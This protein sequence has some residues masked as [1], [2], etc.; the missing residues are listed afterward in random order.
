MKN[1]KRPFNW[2]VLAILTFFFISC[3]LDQVENSFEESIKRKEDS[4]T[5][6]L[7][8]YLESISNF[9]L[10]PWNII[11]EET[12]E[13]EEPFYA[14]VHKQFPKS[15]SFNVSTNPVHRGVKS[16]RFEL[17]KGDPSITDIGVRTEV[18]FSQIENPET[19]Y[20]FSIFLP[21][22]G[23]AR[24]SD[25][26]I[27][28]QWLQSG[29]G[30][31]SI[32]LRTL[33]DRFI[34][35]FRS[36]SG[37]ITSHDLSPATKDSWNRFVF[38]IIHS[39]G[40][41]GLVEIWRNGIKI[42][43]KSGPNMYTGN[44]PRWKL[45]IYKPT[46]ENRSTETQIRI[47]FF[48]NIRIGNE[49]A[50]YEEMNPSNTNKSGW[51]PFIPEIKS[52]T[53]INAFTNKVVKEIFDNEIINIKSLDTDKVTIRANFEETFE[54]S[55]LFNLKGSEI[56]NYVDNS[57][58]NTMYGEDSNGDYFNDGGTPIGNYTL[59]TTTYAERSQNGKIGT[60]KTLKFKIINIEES[61]SNIPSVTSFT[62]IK[63]N[64]D[65]KLGSLKDGDIINLEEV[66]TSKLSI[67][68]NFSSTFIGQLRFRLSGKINRE[69]IADMGPYTLYGYNKG[70]YSFGSTGLPAG[71]YSL[72][73]TPIVVENGI[74]KFGQVI[75]IKFKVVE[76]IDK[77]VLATNYLK[78]LT[79]IKANI[80]QDYG[81]IVDGSV[82]Y[83]NQIGTNKLTIRA[84]MVNEF[85][86]TVL[87]EL[88]GT[89]NRKS[90]S[91]A[92]APY[93]LNGYS[94]GDYSFGEGLPVGSYS[95][96]ITPLLILNGKNSIG[97]ISTIN[98]QIK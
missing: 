62:L 58:P 38:H 76:R 49:N 55:V 59:S 36:N 1:L 70:D 61:N 11:F 30:S 79:L 31:P 18:L 75:T 65:Q 28:S 91:T 8:P 74:I 88:T 45:G 57:T 15:H 7:E 25:D 71:D 40:S 54:G 37:V 68:A 84:N 94:N 9:R 82:F 53:L 92:F 34:Y 80:D 86:G 10:G 41:N 26:E 85:T 81:Q 39:S 95:L 16:G 52:Y 27:L 97:E 56:S 44:L 24:D 43:Q 23:Y 2:T 66:G 42:L 77:I 19:W 6:N 69:Y 51:G 3:N 32:S 78:S 96:K 60:R 48:D 73:T 64:V 47:A 50:T 33:N 21:S 22:N 98:F 90:M 4:N 29:M 46:W 17:R 89:R 72:E 87:F 14:Y 63:A 35:R 93:L 5:F 67:Q 83:A 13:G 20:S 12:F